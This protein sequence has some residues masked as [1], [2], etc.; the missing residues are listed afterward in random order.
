MLLKLLEIS[1]TAVEMIVLSR[2]ARNSEIHRL[3]RMSELDWVVLS[4][5][6]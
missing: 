5:T 4:E 3:R 1:K 6:K 2:A